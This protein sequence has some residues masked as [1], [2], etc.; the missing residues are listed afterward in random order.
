VRVGAD[1]SVWRHILTW[2]ACVWM[3]TSS[4]YAAIHWPCLH[5][6]ALLKKT[7]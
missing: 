7:C 5:Q 6:H 4:E 1:I 3:H 2:C